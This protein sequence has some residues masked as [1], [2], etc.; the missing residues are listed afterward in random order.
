MAPP[1]RTCWSTSMDLYRDAAGLRGQAAQ[2]EARSLFPPFLRR[3][4]ERADAWIEAHPGQTFAM[5]PGL[6]ETA[7]RGGL[8]V[9]PVALRYLTAR[10]V[11]VVAR[12][13]PGPA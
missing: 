5:S 7:R 8:R 13:E 4:L 9:A 1:L 11:E 12:E 6:L 2:D 3:V 10:G